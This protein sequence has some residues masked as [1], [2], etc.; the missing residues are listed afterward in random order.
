M[1]EGEGLVRF[2]SFKGVTPKWSE[3][4]VYKWLAAHI[5]CVTALTHERINQMRSQ[6]LGNSTFESEKT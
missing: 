1:I 4:I 3:T 5:Q 2:F 6:T